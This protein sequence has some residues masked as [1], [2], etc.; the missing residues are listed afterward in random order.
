MRSTHRASR[1]TTAAALTLALGLGAAPAAGA[2]P[3]ADTADK[4][5][6]V[7]G[8][9]A[10]PAADPDDGGWEGEGGLSLNAS[11][12]AQVN[13]FIERAR[14]AERTITPQVRAA[15]RASDAELVGL[16][17]RLK[18]PDSL[19]RKV[20]TSL[21]EDPRQNVNDAIARINDSVRYTFQWRDEQYSTGVTVASHLLAAW[22]NTTTKWSNTWARAKGYKAINS[23][24]RAADSGHLYEIQF[25]TPASKKAQ[26]DTH[27]LYEEQRLPDTT[28]ERA[29]EL[30]RQQDAIFAAVPVPPGAPELTAPAAAPGAV[31]GGAAA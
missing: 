30:Q 16:N 12:N 26:E 21:K 25:H 22:G 7:G 6:K 19:K 28:P 11:D 15:A 1:L 4:V 8:Q 31:R 5:G 3:L 13:A 27:K 10:R 29:E 9:G 20:A 17:H 14:Q 2:S 24:W 18:S 23:A